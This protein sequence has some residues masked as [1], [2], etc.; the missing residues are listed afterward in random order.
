MRIALCL[1]GLVGTND[2]YG[3]GDKIINCKIGYKHFKKNVIDV[4]EKVDVFFHTWNTEH[5]KKLCSVYNPVSYICE[6]QPHYSDENR[7]QAIF[8]RWNSVKKVINLVNQSNN[9]Y[10]FVLLTRFD[11]AFLVNFNFEKYN[12]SKFY[13]QG[14]PGPYKNGLHQMNDLWFF[15]NQENMTKFANLYDNLD[16][17]AYK[18]H[19][20]SS[21]ELVSRHL[22]ETALQK[23]VEYE[24]TRNWNGAQG[25]ISSDTPLV[26]WH[27]MNRL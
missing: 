7:K 8:C 11:I 12:A 1:H 10:D 2:K 19:N 21:H 22:I 26:R 13:V 27:Y 17:D 9:K 4:N 16:E 6:R 14:P 24:F 23:D 25:K 3:I 20:D 15:S 18:I 5:E